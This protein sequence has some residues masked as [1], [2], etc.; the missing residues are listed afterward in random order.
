LRG[1]II[2]ADPKALLAMDM[3]VPSTDF[4]IIQEIVVGTIFY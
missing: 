3:A 1:K 2:I 4:D